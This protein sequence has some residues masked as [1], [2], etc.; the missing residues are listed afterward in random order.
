MK[1]LV[2]VD[3]S[4]Y[5]DEVLEQIA[6]RSWPA[7]TEFSVI[8][9]V[10]PCENWEI[11]QQCVHQSHIILDQRLEHLRTKV[12]PLSVTGHVLVSSAAPAILK[13]AQEWGADL[14]IV[15]SHGDTGTRK[16]GIGSVAA[17]IVN[18][19]PCTVEVVKLRKASAA[20]CGQPGK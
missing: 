16:T 5:A 12:W 8:T 19:A 9:S 15:G 20:A 13:T 3:S 11:Q 6:L 10:E 7:G 18:E 1:V 14:L 17:A 2:G 4:S